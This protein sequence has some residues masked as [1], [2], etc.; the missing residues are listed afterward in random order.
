[1]NIL[2][3]NQDDILPLNN[4]R[5]LYTS[6]FINVMNKKYNL[7]VVKFS[8]LLK[9]NLH[10]EYLGDGVIKC[11]SLNS[12]IG[13]PESLAYKKY[14]SFFTSK[15][16]YEVNISVKKIRSEIEGIIVQKEPDLLIFNHIMTAW[17]LKYFLKDYKIPILYIAHNAESF[18][19]KSIKERIAKSFFE[20]V[21]YKINYYKTRELERHILEKSNFCIVLTDEDGRRIKSLSSCPSVYTI[22]PIFI[23]SS[24]FLE[25]TIENQTLLLVGSFVWRPKQANALWLANKVFPK[26]LEKFP[27]A[28]LKIVGSGAN[29]L[30]KN[31]TSDNV[32]IYSDVKDVKEFYYSR[33][34]FIIPERQGGG[35]K[36][37]TLESASF[38]LPIVSTKEGI[39]GTGL[40]DNESCMEA[41]NLNEMLDKISLLFNDINL[42]NKI[43]NKANLIIQE[44]FNQKVI[45]D[46]IYSLL[47][48]V[49]KKENNY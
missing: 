43:S 2:F 4:G 19:M 40:R 33:P 6:Q 35:L 32:F 23:S 28:R 31:I 3:F 44:N 9:L 36:L 42:C 39:E 15:T 46:K 47:N 12:K 34:I 21:F 25:N 49:S 24:R 37:K 18:A 22:P 14:L 30:T 45:N 1:M 38:G 20:K 29:K 16:H 10:E 5:K 8:S 27:Q 26:V 41:N 48:T 7:T 17:V 11:L 13:N